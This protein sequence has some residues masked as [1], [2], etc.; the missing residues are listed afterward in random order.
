MKKISYFILILSITVVNCHSSYNKSQRAFYYWKQQCHLTSEDSTIFKQLHITKLYVRYFDLVRQSGQL[1]ITPPVSIGS[2][3]KLSE[4]EVIPVVFITPEALKGLDDVKIPDT[5]NQ[6]IGT[7][8]KIGQNAGLTPFKEFQIDC[9]WTPSTKDRFF[10]LL[11]ILKTLTEMENRT[12][13]CTIRLHQLADPTRTGIPPVDRGMLMPYNLDPV[14]KP[15][16]TDSI[17]DEKLLRSYIDRSRQYPLL[18][19]IVLPIFTWAAHFD[20]DKKF[21]GLIRDVTLNDLKENNKLKNEKQRFYRAS[22][23][24]YIRDI[25]IIKGDYIRLDGATYNNL[26]RMA[27]YLEKKKRE[28]MKRNPL[29][30]SLFHYSPQTVNAI[31]D[32]KPERLEKIFEKWE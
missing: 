21:L 4:I 17:M 31:T 15:G 25:K 30:I 28:I 3:L 26:M 7:V 9:D 20:M 1:T 19:D 5:V 10:H 2:N 23:T 16:T 18:L 27:G 14:H 32:G 12:L 8:I 29:T 13:S 24:T 11:K 22:E 6:L